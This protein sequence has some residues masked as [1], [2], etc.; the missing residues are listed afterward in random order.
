MC[1]PTPVARNLILKKVAVPEESNIGVPGRQYTMRR[2]AAMRML[3]VGLAA[4]LLL[5]GCG[6]EGETP[7]SLGPAPSGPV[8]VLSWS[9]PTTYN[10]N[11]P[12]DPQRDLDYYE[13]YVRQDP[14]FTESDQ[15]VI[16]LS[17]VAS[18]LSPDG[19]TVT[20]LLVKDFTLELI[21]S[22]PAGNQLY[23]SMRAVGI[24]HQKSGFMAPLLWDRS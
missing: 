6:G 12:L 19:L 21:P 14:N 9:P 17:A 2:F 8:S 24:D 20:R 18:T 3:L 23:V 5:A 1:A 11:A 13:V 7:Q 15:P 4:V 10:D 22:L 16:Q